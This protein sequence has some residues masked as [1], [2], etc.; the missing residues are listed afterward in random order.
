MWLWAHRG[1]SADAP[2][3]TLA[4]FREAVE[5]GAD[6]VEL[7]VQR[8]ASGEVV[9]CH[10]PQL[11]RLAGLPW[12]VLHTPWW[13]LRRADVGTKL[14]FSPERIPLLEEVLEL[15]PKHLLVNVE[16][17]CDTVE[18]HGLTQA[19]VDVVRRLRAE[20]RVVFSSFNALCLWRLGAIAPELRRGYL[21]DPDR[22]FTVH[23]RVIAPLVSNHAVHPW[24]EQVTPARMRL[25]KTAGLRV[26]VWTVDDPVEAARLRALGVDA[27]ITNQPGRLR[28]APVP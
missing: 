6:G 19:A 7:D 14:G 9:V 20:D 10:D 3:N 16:L 17:K 28:A 13:K 27:L 22:S 21:V 25:W 5:Q 23:G 24:R 12:E 26:N 2:E 1:A 8:C 4:A 18:D 11:D 15:L